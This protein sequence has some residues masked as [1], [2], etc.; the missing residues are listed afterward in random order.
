MS[1]RL[2]LDKLLAEMSTVI[3]TIIVTY[4][5]LISEMASENRLRVLY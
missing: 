3:D 2:N 1:E 4:K 5:V